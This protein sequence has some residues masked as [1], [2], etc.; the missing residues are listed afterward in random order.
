M[1]VIGHL[2]ATP[3]RLGSPALR[4]SW[5]QEE[6]AMTVEEEPLPEQPAA[7]PLLQTTCKS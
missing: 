3:V 7:E 1:E 6:V 5:S 4:P 2:R